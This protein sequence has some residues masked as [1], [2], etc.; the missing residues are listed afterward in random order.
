[1]SYHR[2]QNGHRTAQAHV[3]NQL[4]LTPRQTWMRRVPLLPR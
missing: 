4:E 3:P 2:G 1:M